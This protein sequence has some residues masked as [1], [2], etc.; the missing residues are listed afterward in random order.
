MNHKV[1]TVMSFYENS[2]Q[3]YLDLCLK[4]L[5]KQEDV[6]QEIIVA[7]SALTPPSVPE[8]V[9]LLNLSRENKAAQNYNIAA[10][11]SR[12]G[13]EFLF[14]VN[15][16]IIASSRALAT[17]INLVG[18]NHIILNA[19]S[20]SDMGL[21]YFSDFH[22]PKN[23][24]PI[25]NVP[26]EW[27]RLKQ[28][29]RLDDIKGFEEAIMSYNPIVQFPMLIPVPY[30]CMYATLFRKEVWD[31]LGGYDTI[32]LAMTGDDTDLAIRADEI[33]VKCY[34]TPNAFIFHFGGATTSNTMTDNHRKIGLEM[35]EKKW[36]IDLRKLNVGKLTSLKN[37]M[38]ASC[39]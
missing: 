25:Q 17:M 33:G 13:T 5:L 37:A 3:P 28:F 16:D 8:G 4:S 14:T 34:I 10:N 18:N 21:L 24:P 23:N 2:N 29:M 35:F 38:K 31:K 12:P 7:S 20:N 11:E 9:K 26:N 22:I 36:G 27:I 32:N 19:A 30:L 15:D 1:T 6:D 39:L